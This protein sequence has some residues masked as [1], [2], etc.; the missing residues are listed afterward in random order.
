MVWA[1]PRIIVLTSGGSH[2]EQTM[3]SLERAGIVPA[4]L[5]I[6]PLP[7]RPLPV[8]LRHALRTRGLLGTMAIAA[9]RAAARFRR[10]TPPWWDGLASRVTVTGTLNSPAMVTALAELRPDWLVLAGTG[11][12]KPPVLAVPTQGTLNAH[13]GL[14][15]YV[16]G[17]GVVDRAIER[18]WPVGVTVHRVDAGI[19]TG[20]VFRR[21]LVPVGADDSLASLRAKAD[22]QCVDMLAETVAAIAA[23]A[24]LPNA[25]AQTRCF[26]YCRWPDIG[27]K[28]RIETLVRTGRA[29]RAY[30]AARALAGG[31][32]LPGD[33]ELTAL[34]HD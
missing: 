23:G 29:R 1:M 4:A 34:N 18:G 7:T 17:T 19:D 21:R 30:D 2:G 28:R 32:E 14:L 5:M 12:V 27:E 31:D 25:L 20:P 11:I 33:L 16:R 15:P 8:M 10:R 9:A 13:P 26:D 6:A 24:P 3:A 22:R